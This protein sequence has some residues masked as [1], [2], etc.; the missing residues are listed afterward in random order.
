MA[1]PPSHATPRSTRPLPA[2]R[3]P[4]ARRHRFCRAPR[5]RRRPAVHR[6]VR[7]QTPRFSRWRS[8][9]SSLLKA[10]DRR[11]R[12]RLQHWPNTGRRLPTCRCC[13]F[14]TKRPHRICHAV[15]DRPALLGLPRVRSYEQSGRTSPPQQTDVEVPCL[16]LRKSSTSGQVP[17]GGPMLARMK[18][19]TCS[20]ASPL[21]QRTLRL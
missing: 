10:L 6:L 16:A 17:R 1:R 7:V 8:C 12:R 20:C 4:T 19:T 3:W 18:V 5:C 11:T 2:M 9:G 21:H 13:H 14:P 15:L